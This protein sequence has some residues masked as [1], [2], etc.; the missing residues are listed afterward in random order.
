MVIG[1]VP[2]VTIEE[3]VAGWG[4]PDFFGAVA[5]KIAPSRDHLVLACRPLP[6]SQ[7]S[8]KSANTSVMAPHEQNVKIAVS[9]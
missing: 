4:E 3:M 9:C 1:S 2:S 6:V 5:Y 7:H 8:H